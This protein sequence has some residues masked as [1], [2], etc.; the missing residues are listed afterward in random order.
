MFGECNFIDNEIT[1]YLNKE[2]L[3]DY[4]TP[5]VIHYYKPVYPDA[6]KAT[7]REG[8]ILVEV[9]IKQNGMVSDAKILDTYPEESRGYFDQSVLKSAEK[10]VFAQDEKF[11]GKKEPWAIIPYVFICDR[12]S[13]NENIKITIKN[14]VDMQKTPKKLLS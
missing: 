2:E 3:H 13:V 8:I 14:L 1:L 5:E 7:E 12:S 4:C 9:K 10:F 11:T 6:A